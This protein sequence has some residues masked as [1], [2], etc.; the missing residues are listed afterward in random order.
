LGCPRSF[1]YFFVIRCLA[2]SQGQ[3]RCFGFATTTSG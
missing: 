1:K 3:T 2:K